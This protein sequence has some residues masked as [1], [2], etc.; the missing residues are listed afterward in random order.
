MFPANS[1]RQSASETSS[2]A[3]S[4]SKRSRL[5]DQHSGGAGSDSL[6][7]IPSHGI[8]FHPLNLIYFFI[9]NDFTCTSSAKQ[10]FRKISIE[11]PNF[12]TTHDGTQ[13][14]NKCSMERATS[15]AHVE[16]KEKLDL[17]IDDLIALM[18]IGYQDSQSEDTS[19]VR[20]GQCSDIMIEKVDITVSLFA[21]DPCSLG[22][23]PP[24]AHPTVAKAVENWI[25]AATA[26]TLA[27]HVTSIFVCINF[28]KGQKY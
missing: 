1:T 12:E 7:S 27:R 20:F 24:V 25:S 13:R 21:K 14:S 11:Q 28:T 4:A 22:S 23:C 15:N 9:T 16:A 19:T 5:P 18:N 2:T 6:L 26:A 3:R 8:F 10:P 17:F